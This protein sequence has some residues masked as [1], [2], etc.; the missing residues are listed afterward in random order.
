MVGSARHESDLH[1]LRLWARD[2]RQLCASLVS[3][4]K[5][6]DSVG[7]YPKAVSVSAED[8]GMEYPMICW[9]FGRPDENGKVSDRVKYGMLGVIIHEVGHN[10]FPMIVNSDERQWTWMDEG[11]NTFLEYL[12]EIEWESTFPVDRGPARLIVPYM[13]GNQQYLEPIMSQGD[14]V[15]NFG[16]NAY[17]KPATGLNILRETI[18]GHELFD[19]A[20]KTYANRW[21]FKHPT[22]EDFFRTMEDASAVDLDW[23]WKG[24]FYSTDFVDIGIK[25]VKQYYVT[26]SV[27]KEN[28]ESF[29]RRGRRVS[30]DQG[31]T[32]YLL[33]EDSADLKAEN[34]K[35][36][37]AEEV[38]SLNE[39]LNKKYTAEERKNM[40]NPK[41]FYEVEF[42]KPGG[43]IMPII[44]ELQ[45]EDGT[46]EIHKFPAQIWR[47]NNEV[48]KRTFATD[49]KV[50]K[51][52]VDPKLETADIDTTNNTWPKQETT[53]KFDQ[54]EK[55]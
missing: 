15:Y 37:N 55:K 40:K 33:P 27:T 32:I 49:K 20:F 22:P 18:M 36:F 13:K 17:G 44:A 46:S 30:G 53:S 12:T 8:Q 5:K 35:A 14:V 25:N 3:A 51:I 54:L 34:K 4:N 2:A 6:D 50:V 7:T 41:F 45:F 1:P 9:N 39:F 47:R 19:H 29:N 16:A 38:Q 48:A 42:D 23:F 21:K 10:F 26:E 31:P 28:K 52:V 11:L 43:M 24:W